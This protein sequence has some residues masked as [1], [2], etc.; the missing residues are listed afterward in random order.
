VKNCE[1]EWQP[2]ALIPPPPD[3]SAPPLLQ[4]WAYCYERKGY[5]PYV[6]A[7]DEPWELVEAG[8]PREIELPTKPIWYFCESTKRYFPYAAT[9]GGQWQSVPA[10]PPPNPVEAEQRIGSLPVH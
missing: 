6:N 9:C 8:T 2:V 7:C 4:G 1:H 5:Y 10:M 3:S